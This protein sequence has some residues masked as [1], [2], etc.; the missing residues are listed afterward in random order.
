MFELMEHYE[1][2]NNKK[3]VLKYITMASGMPMDWW[4]WIQCIQLLLHTI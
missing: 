2:D 1:E 3:S 4:E